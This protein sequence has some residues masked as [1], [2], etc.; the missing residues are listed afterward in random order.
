MTV[1]IDAKICRE[2]NCRYYGN[3]GNMGFLLRRGCK[4][5]W[6]KC[7][8]YL[9]DEDPIPLKCLNRS[10]MLVSSK[11]IFNKDRNK[12]ML[13]REMMARRVNCQQE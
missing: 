13:I 7:G 8:V 6:E 2:T 1:G 12:S 4:M 3:S 11:N 10:I 5:L 9:V